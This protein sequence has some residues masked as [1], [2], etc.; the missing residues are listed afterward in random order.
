[1]IWTLINLMHDAV[2]DYVYT[3]FGD[4]HHFTGLAY[5]IDAAELVFDVHAWPGSLELELADTT[6]RTPEWFRSTS[7]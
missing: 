3:R 6:W 5:V 1:M 4:L 7:A 2:E